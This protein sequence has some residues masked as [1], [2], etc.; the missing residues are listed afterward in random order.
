[1]ALS[2]VK[3]KAAHMCRCYQ[4]GQY[5]QAVG[6]ALD[7]CRLDKL[8]EAITRSSDQAASLTYALKTCQ[9]T[10]INRGFRQEVRC[11]SA[12]LLQALSK[13]RPIATEASK[14]LTPSI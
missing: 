5:E 1:M 7:V 13:F 8:E 14:T 12:C 10:V 9:Q 11:W 6:L 3:L 2:A 4:D